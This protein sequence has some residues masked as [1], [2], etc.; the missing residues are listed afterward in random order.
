ML[1]DAKLDDLWKSRLG[2]QAK[3]VLAVQILTVKR[4][5]RLPLRLDHLY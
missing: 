2:T 4:R 5:N 1:W 3:R